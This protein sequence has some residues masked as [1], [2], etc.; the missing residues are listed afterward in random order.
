MT[1]AQRLYA[2]AM[3]AAER[4]WR[5]FPLRPDDKRPAVKDWQTRATCDPDR[6][7]ACWAAGPFNIGIACGPSGLL[8][9][10]LDTPKPDTPPMPPPFDTPDVRDG[11]D[12]LAVLA[13]QH[14]Q[15]FPTETF[16]QRTGRGG[17]HL[18]FTAPDGGLRNT[19]GRLG[20][21]IDTRGIGG[22]VVGPGSVV[23]GRPYEV[24][25]NGA[26]HLLPGWIGRLLNPPA[27]RAEPS[28][29]AAR[30]A[31]DVRMVPLVAYVLDAAEGTRN[32]SLFWAAKK[33]W[34]HIRDGDIATGPALD[35]LLDAA[36]SIGL[37]EREARATIESAGRQ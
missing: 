36:L 35:S 4:G 37:P 8:V 17:E 22:Y 12:V 29:P 13:E 14:G 30:S 21:L 3:A 32:A 15:P 20:P 23:N 5:V 31:A 26:V 1:D 10:D 2:H 9:I 18:F 7:A 11:A 16:A 28:Q 6:I 33:A 19:A 24:I 25:H 27:H 34:T